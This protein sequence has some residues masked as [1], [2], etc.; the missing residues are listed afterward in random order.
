MKEPLEKT[1]V[2]H[3][4]QCA[5][6]PVRRKANSMVPLIKHERGSRDGQLL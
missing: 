3:D 6:P 4:L 1:M 2:P 5:L